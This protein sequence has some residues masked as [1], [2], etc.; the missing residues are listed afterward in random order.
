MFDDS[1]GIAADD[2]IVRHILRHNSSGGN[3]GIPADGHTRADDGTHANPRIVFAAGPRRINLFKHTNNCV[4][5]LLC[6]AN[7]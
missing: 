2:H 6:G 4:I 3:D 7:I 5:L 1:G